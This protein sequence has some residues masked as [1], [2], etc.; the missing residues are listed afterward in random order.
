MAA[1]TA[2]VLSNMAA[3]TADVLS[4]MAAESTA[5]STKAVGCWE[6]SPVKKIRVLCPRGI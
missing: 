5:Q 3:G 6:P 2:D 4:N 1:G